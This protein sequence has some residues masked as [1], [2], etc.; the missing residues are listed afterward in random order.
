MKT[1]QLSLRTHNFIKFFGVLLFSYLFLISI[2]YTKD[3]SYQPLITIFIALCFFA[4]FKVVDSLLPKV[5]IRP[6]IIGLIFIGL[7]IR[8]YW[9]INIMTEPIS[10]FSHYHQ[11]AISLAKGEAIVHKNIG[12]VLLLSIGYKIFPDVFTGKLINVGFSTFSLI[13]LYL[14][15]KKLLDERKALYALLLFTFLPSEIAMCSVLGSEV[16]VSWASITVLYFM[17]KSNDFQIQRPKEILFL[18]ISGF[19]YGLSL[20]LKTVM[21]FYFPAILVGFFIANVR[22]TYEFLKTLVCFKFGIFL[23][24]TTI[25]LIYTLMSGSFTFDIFIAQDPLP[26][27]YGTNTASQGQWN[28]ADTELYYSF[29]YNERFKLTVNEALDRI[30]DKPM[31]F[32]LLIPI[33]LYHLMAQNDY[34]N[35]WNLLYVN[36]GARN[37]LFALLS[38]AVYVLIMGLSL[39]SCYT[40]PK[41]DNTFLITTV[42]FL[43]V[44]TLIPH[45]ILE[46]QSRYHHHLLP[47]IILLAANGISKILSKP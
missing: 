10:D 42:I 17:V 13:F 34:G 40:S 44:S 6:I 16:I 22:N 46:S 39:Y 9:V 4:L 33:K 32:I 8:L 20:T 14:I 3:V 47:F 41:G 2:S 45:V 27:L 23:G 25:S 19:F 28:M 12:F 37:L 7:L 15:G 24:I 35:E 29:P 1:Q 21:I 26:L 43:I 38:Q 5:G 31:D 30:K 11:K 36:M 18:L